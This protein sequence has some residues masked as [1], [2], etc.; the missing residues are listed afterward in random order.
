MEQ[1]LRETAICSGEGLFTLTAYWGR[2]GTSIKMGIGIICRGRR[3]EYRYRKQAVPA[4]TMDRY[5]SFMRMQLVELMGEGAGGQVI[6]SLG[7][8][9]EGCSIKAKIWKQELEVWLCPTQ[10]H[11][12][13]LVLLT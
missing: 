4:N 11:R 6:A 5:L 2:A 1:R 13:D 7:Y 3:I 8:F 9:G 10:C 12:D